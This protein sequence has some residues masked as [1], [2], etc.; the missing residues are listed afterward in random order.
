MARMPCS[1]RVIRVTM[2]E[3]TPQNHLGSH[4]ANL[5]YLEQGHLNDH[6]HPRH[7]DSCNLGAPGPRDP[8]QNPPSSLRSGS[9]NFS[10]SSMLMSSTCPERIRCQF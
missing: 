10:G 6:R 8:I 2:A 4:R 7:Y 5:H 9:G 1:Y 3:K